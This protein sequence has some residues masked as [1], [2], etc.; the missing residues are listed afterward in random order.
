MARRMMATEKMDINQ[1][2]VT[3]LTPRSDMRAGISG[4]T[5]NRLAAT[6]TLARKT[7]SV[8]AQA[9]RRESGVMDA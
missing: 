1:P 5:L 3:M 9:L 6:A 4:G 8:T 7:A 2:P